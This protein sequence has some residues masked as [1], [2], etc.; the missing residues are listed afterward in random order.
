MGLVAI[1]KTAHRRKNR[2]GRV[3]GAVDGKSP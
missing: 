1:P 3:A 2:T